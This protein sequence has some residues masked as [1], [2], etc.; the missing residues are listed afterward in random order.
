MDL[1]D[2]HQDNNTSIGTP[3]ASKMRPTSLDEL[4]GQSHIVGKGKL[5]DRAIRAGRLGSCI[6]WGAT[7]CG[8][9]T[10]ARL[11]AQ[12]SSANCVSLNAISSGVSDAKRVI[13]EATTLKHMSGKSTYLLLDE[14]HRWSK[15]QSDSVLAAI[16]EGTIILIGCTTENPSVSLT[17]AIVSRCRVFEFLPLDSQDILHALNRC[18]GKSDS[19]GDL[20]VVVDS[21]ALVQLSQ[22]ANGDLR[23]AYNALELAVSSTPL[24]HD[25]SVRITTIDIEQCI[26]R[27]A[28]SIDESDYYDMLSAF[29]KSLRGSAP[30]AAL[31]WAFGLMQAGV[32]PLIVLRRLIA[33]ASEDVGMADSQ[34]LVVANNAYS[35]Y[36]R[37]GMPEGRLAIGHA[38]VYVA[39][40]PKSN[41]VYLAIQQ[42]MQDAKDCATVSVPYYLRDYHH[43][44]YRVDNDGFEYKYPHD[45]PDNWVEQEYMPRELVGKVYYRHSNSKDKVD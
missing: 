39:N 29:G 36:E 40:A 25:G 37:L 28:L 18:L 23:V 8:K 41:A 20:R 38:I 21:D 34:A 3:L 22:L 17:R 7:G 24:Q 44:Q 2:Y 5:L 42:A 33:H 10:L 43:R 45:Y 26:S 4:V 12:Y 13:E 16:E 35:A 1:L 11:V 30:D 31:Y 27:K 9:T 6:F 15:A 32:D 19:F 14:C